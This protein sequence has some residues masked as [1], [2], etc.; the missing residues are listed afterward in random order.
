MTVPDA[1]DDFRAPGPGADQRAPARVPDRGRGLTPT[2]AAAPP[3]DAEALPRLMLGRCCLGVVQRF[4]C[5]PGA[6]GPS[7][8]QPGAGRITD[9][10][11][12]GDFRGYPNS[13]PQRVRSDLREASDPE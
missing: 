12:D 13:G 5:Y 7:S 11:A 8:L 1:A 9:N 3:D 2:R 6:P 10:D 4:R